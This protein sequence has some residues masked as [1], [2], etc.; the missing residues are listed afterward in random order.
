MFIDTLKKIKDYIYKEDIKEIRR[1]LDCLDDIEDYLDNEDELAGL[2]NGVLE[3]FQKLQ[4]Y[5]TELH[6]L[7][8]RLHK[9]F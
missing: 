6:Q 1:Y 2:P 4:C 5:F 3:A 9:Q 7:R 8:T